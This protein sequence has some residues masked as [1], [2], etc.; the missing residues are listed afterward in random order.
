MGKSNTT[1]THLDGGNDD[2]DKADFVLEHECKPEE[3]F[4]QC[5]D[6][7]DNI[8]WTKEDAEFLQNHG[9]SF[10][11][12]QPSSEDYAKLNSYLQT[13]EVAKEVKKESLAKNYAQEQ[14]RANLVRERDLREEEERK[15]YNQEREKNDPVGVALKKKQ[16][17]SSARETARKQQLAEIKKN[18]EEAERLRKSS[19]LQLK[20]SAMPSLADQRMVLHLMRGMEANRFRNRRLSPRFSRPTSP[21][22]FSRERRRSMRSQRRGPSSR[23]QRRQSRQSQKQS[24]LAALMNPQQT[25]SR[26]DADDDGADQLRTMDGLLRQ[27]DSRSRSRPRS[28]SSFSVKPRFSPKPRSRPRS[29]TGSKPKSRPRSK[30]GS[31]RKSRPRSQTGSKPKYSPRSRPRS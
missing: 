28:R 17:E 10:I 19:L 4:R 11:A 18:A 8:N 7:Q 12:P 25:R 14:H 3:T 31:K 1:Q 21:Q 30:T 22:V 23:N 20:S 6:R 29:K 24:Q 2:E 15:I 26:L 13:L 16:D 27:F 9:D 5:A